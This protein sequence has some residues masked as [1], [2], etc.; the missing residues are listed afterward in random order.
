MSGRSMEVLGVPAATND[1]FAP[2]MDH[3]SG[4]TPTSSRASDRRTTGEPR[5]YNLKSTMLLK[6]AGIRCDRTAMYHKLLAA[7]TFK[8]VCLRSWSSLLASIGI[9]WKIAPQPAL[10]V[11]EYIE[12]CWPF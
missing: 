8:R 11:L 7:W 12:D 9:D 5:D 2:P 6:V 3:S 4:S 1:R 10:Q